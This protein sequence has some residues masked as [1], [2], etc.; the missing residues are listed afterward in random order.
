M[1]CGKTK[2][3]FDLA[4]SRQ[5]L[6]DHSRVTLD[7]HHASV[8]NAEASI[9]VDTSHQNSSLQIS[10]PPQKER[11]LDPRMAASRHTDK[12]TESRQMASQADTGLPP[13]EEQLKTAAKI[14]TRP[15][16]TLTRSSSSQNSQPEHT[17]Y[18][19]VHREIHELMESKVEAC[20]G[21]RNDISAELI[22]Q[23][24][25]LIRLRATG[26]EQDRISKSPMPT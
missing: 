24:L 11:L 26:S 12:I 14:T 10:Q 25:I 1:K 22:I 18:V 20:R 7:T 3:C 17:S 19:E 5:T 13:N 16:N 6:T 15:V 2:M 9:F 21:R 23:N 8:L 4:D